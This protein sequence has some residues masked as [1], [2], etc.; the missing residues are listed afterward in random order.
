MSA[1]VM[2]FGPAYLDRVLRVDRPLIDRDLGP[3]SIRAWKGRAGS[4]PAGTSSSSSRP[5]SVLEITLPESWPGPFGQVV[6][7]SELRPVAQARA[8][9]TVWAGRDDLGGMGAGYAAA[10]GGTLHHALGSEDDPGSRAVAELLAREGVVHE[11]IRIRDH[12]ADWTLLVTSGADGD[13]LAI[14]FRGCHAALAQDAFDPW[15]AAPCDLRVVAGLPNPLAARVSRPPAP[16]PALRPGD[17]KHARSRLSRLRFRR[18]DRSALL[19][20]PGVGDAPRPRGDGVEGL[21]PGGDRRPRRSLGPLHLALGRSGPAPGARIP[22]R[23]APGRHQPRRRGLRGDLRVRL[24][25][26]RLESRLRRRRA[27]AGPA[28]HAPRLRPPP[29]WSSIGW[30]LGFPGPRR[31][32]P[33]WMPGGSCNSPSLDPPSSRTQ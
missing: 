1:K 10:L 28:S 23:P 31:S 7:A 9:S 8:W 15:L 32:T 6:L 20:P 12:P 13:K 24:A 2:V 27:R 3:P 21:D 11:P 19:Q 17:A 25:L 4:V 22:S 16:L 33:R 29:P 5:G 14:G 18:F 26:P 30:I